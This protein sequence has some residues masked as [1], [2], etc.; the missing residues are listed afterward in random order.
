MTY[1]L[2]DAAW[3]ARETER[4]KGILLQHLV[5]GQEYTVAQVLQVLADYGLDYTNPEYVEIG[6]QLVADGVIEAVP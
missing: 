5:K 1:K 2:T 4:A 3:L 6:N